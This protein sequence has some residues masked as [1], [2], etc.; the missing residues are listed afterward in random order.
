MLDVKAYL[1]KSGQDN[2]LITF[3]GRHSW[4]P[5]AEIMKAFDWLAIQAHLKGKIVIPED[6]I[7][8]AYHRNYG[9]AAKLEASGH[10]L[11]AAENYYRVISSYSTFYTL[12]SVI[13]GLEDLKKGSV[14]KHALKARKEAV[15][16]EKELTDALYKQFSAEY[17][18]PDK[19]DLQWWKKKLTQ[20]N[21]KYAG[22]TSEF[23]LMLERVQFY[24]YAMAYSRTNPN[25]YQASEEQKN[26]CTKLCKL[27]Y[28][29]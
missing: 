28:Q 29:D 16:K 24:V 21:D 8:T 25:L 3:S 17:N 14:Y 26:F 27:V 9:S 1:E 11:K 12:D 7:Y 15:E 20:L 18:N 10:L 4:P 22:S 13:T 23:Q 5:P 2:P 19:I 6:K